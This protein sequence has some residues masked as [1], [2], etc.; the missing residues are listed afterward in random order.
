[1]LV[2]DAIIV[3]EHIYTRIEA[4]DEPELAAIKGAEDVTSPVVCAIATTVVAFAPLLFIK[5]RMG[6]FMGVLPL[7]VIFALSISLFEALTILPSHLAESFTRAARRQ[8]AQVTRKPGPWRRFR[9]RLRAGQLWFFDGVLRGGYAGFLRRAVAYRYVTIAVAVAG[10]IVVGGAMAGGVVDVVF[11]QKMDAETLI[12]SVE[13][14]VGSPLS[15]TDRVM[16]HVEQ[17]TGDIPEMGTRFTLMGRQMSI[18]GNDGGSSTAQSHIGQMIMELVPS[19]ER[20]RSSTDILRELR[21]NTADLAGVNSI[22]FTAV[23][24]GPGGAAIEI[25]ITGEEFD[26]LVAATAR[27]QDRL[28][29]FDGVS[30]IEDDFDA[31]QREVQVELLDSGRTLGLTTQSLA[32]QVRAAFYGLEARKIQ[33][34][35]EDVKIM[36]RYPESTRARLVDLYQMRVATPDGTLTPISEVA[37]IKEGIGY[38]SIKRKNHQ[39]AVTVKADVDQNVA[40]SREIL[41]SL[42][43]ELDQMRLD[44]PGIQFNFAGESEESAKSFSSI[45]RDG[46]AAI[47]LI[48]V[49][50]AGLFKSYVQ[51]LIVMTAIPFGMIGAVVG[52]Y[53]MG[54]PMTV[55][56][57]IGLVALAGIAV[58]DSLILVDFI[59]RRIAEGVETKEAVVQGGLARL[60]A[61]MLTSITTILGLAPLL[62][63]KSFQAKFLIPMGISIAFGLAFSTLLILVVVP[64]LYV[65]LED[66]RRAALAG[67]RWI[68]PSPS[69]AVDR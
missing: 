62:T 67:L 31:G 65:I 42:T 14:P 46:L 8:R 59:N 16:T 58:N 45:Q 26:H 7:I 35:R 1:M 20:T 21:E 22:T 68:W 32:T 40:N 34:D 36:V 25:E 29:G 10:L 41:A 37:R 9:E 61:I 12:A 51:P 24:G 48:Y 53:V 15:Q 44:Y 57:F 66:V 47:V 18:G 3:G 2:D 19:E 63:E 55:L 6:D 38:A 49:I 4:G 52:H 30:D 50:L 56:S 17:V 23:H 28:R 33:R 60:R 54:Y 39:R 11:L 27:I 5:G 69:V 13:L 43:P 64:C